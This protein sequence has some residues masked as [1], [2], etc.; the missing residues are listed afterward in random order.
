MLRIKVVLQVTYDLALARF[1]MWAQS[2]DK[3][4]VAILVPTGGL[5]FEL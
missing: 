1:Y 4:F 5:L 3:V 2:E